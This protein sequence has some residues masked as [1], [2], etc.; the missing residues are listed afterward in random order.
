MI[1]VAG[2]GVRNERLKVVDASVQSFHHAVGGDHCVKDRAMNREGGS[3]AAGHFSDV[4]GGGDGEILRG[5]PNEF[6]GTGQL[7]I[8]EPVVLFC[9]GGGQS[10]RMAFPEGSR[11][12]GDTRLSHGGCAQGREA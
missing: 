12:D 3:F 9:I 2:E 4:G 10:G 7:S 11:E 5:D 8:D 1:S 6:A